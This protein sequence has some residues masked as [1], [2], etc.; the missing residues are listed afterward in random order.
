MDDVDTIE[1]FEVEKSDQE[2]HVTV[3][4]K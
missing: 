2:G 1:H 3:E 4:D